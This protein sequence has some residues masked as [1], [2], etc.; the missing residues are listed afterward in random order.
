[1]CVTNSQ[2]PWNNF[3]AIFQLLDVSK[4]CGLIVSPPAPFPA[5]YLL[6]AITYWGICCILEQ[7][8]FGWNEGWYA[9]TP[10]HG[11]IVGESTHICPFVLMGCQVRKWRG[12]GRGKVQRKGISVRERGAGI[13]GRRCTS[14]HW[15]SLRIVCS[16]RTLKITEIRGKRRTR[17]KYLAYLLK[18]QLLYGYLA[19][20]DQERIII[21][22]HR[23]VI[24]P[25]PQN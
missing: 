9:T 15:V 8:L 25:N 19:T 10:I 6:F 21:H 2:V 4:Q 11:T 13:E 12:R 5:L 7:V 22:D 1:M 24:L 23:I 16:D 17:G 18:F 20:T 3:K 14:G